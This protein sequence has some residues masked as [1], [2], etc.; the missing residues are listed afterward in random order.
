MNQNNILIVSVA[1]IGKVVNAISTLLVIRVIATNQGVDYASVFIVLTGLLGWYVLAD[2]GI[3][4]SIQ[5]FISESRAL[6]RSYKQ[7]IRLATDAGILLLLIGVGLCYL[8]SDE[9]GGMLLGN[10]LFLSQREMASLF[11]I[12]AVFYIAITVGSIGYKIWY[13]EQLGYLANVIPAIGA[14]LGLML[15]YF[16][17]QSDLENKIFVS[18]IA[19][20]SP[21][22]GAS[23]AS[24]F[25]RIQFN[26]KTPRLEWGVACKVLSRGASF[27]LMSLTQAIIVNIDFII[28]AMFASSK[29]ILIYGIISRLFGFATFFYTSIYTGLWPRFTE[30][31]TKK[32]WNL[33]RKILWLSF[34]FSVC[35][36]LCFS[37]LLFLMADQIIAFLAPGENIQVTRTLI[38]LL[39]VYHLVIAWVHGYGIVLQSMSDTRLFLL[40]MPIQ[41][42]INL[43]LQVILVPIFGLNGLVVGMTLSFILTLV[44][45]LPFRVQKHMRDNYFAAR[46]FFGGR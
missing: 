9:V 32:D 41:A 19:Y 45:I 30:L 42:V 7:Y 44:W 13:A 22:A 2:F 5:N 24:L 40:W 15:V 12:S 14:V 36:I 27:F 6:H 25:Y 3:G 29:D 28:L 8:L 35:L 21:L 18:L 37:I 23:L 16:V 20:L 39:T 31:I 10:F 1:W 26:E 34:A 46:S 38:A 33:V 43:V 11:F 4:S 17:Q